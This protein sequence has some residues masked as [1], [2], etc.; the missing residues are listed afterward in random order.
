MVKRRMISSRKLDYTEPW[1]LD[2]DWIGQFNST[3]PWS[4][5]VLTDIHIFFKVAITE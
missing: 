5:L 3:S 4:D 2:L 1:L